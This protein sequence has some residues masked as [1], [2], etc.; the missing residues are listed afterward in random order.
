MWH[1]HHEVRVVDLL[2]LLLLR[3]L[4]LHELVCVRDAQRLKVD[5]VD[6]RDIRLRLPADVA[7]AVRLTAVARL[8]LM[9]EQRVVSHEGLMMGL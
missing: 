1:A 8:C 9:A 2:P 4:E 5:I 7:Y 6:D 3:A